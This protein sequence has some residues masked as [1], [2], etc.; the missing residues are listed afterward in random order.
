MNEENDNEATKEYWRNLQD[1]RRDNYYKEERR[2]IEAN[3]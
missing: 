3:D 2:R 1:E